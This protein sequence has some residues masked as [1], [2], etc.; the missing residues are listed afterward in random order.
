[1]KLFFLI[2]SLAGGG[3]EAV[4]LRLQGSI[5]PDKIILLENDAK[6]DVNKE[7]AVIL[8][9]H[10]NKTNP[11]YK[12]F[13]IPFYV[14]KILKKFKIGQDSV[15]ISFLERS[16][17]VN[18]ITKMIIKHKAIVT[19]H[20]DITNKK[21]F[22]KN[23][24]K[25]LMKLLYPK[26]DVIISVSN[27]VKEALKKMG[28]E[29]SKIKTIYNS[30]PIEEI[31]EKSKYPIEDI[32]N[33]FIITVGR[34]IEPKGQWYLLRIFKEVKKQFPDLKLVI[35]GEG[36]LKNYLVDL[37][38]RLGLKTFVWDKDNLNDMYDVYFLGFKKNPYKY[39][40]KAKF[41]VLTS[42]YEGFGNVLVE[43]MICNTCIISTDC[44]SG[45]REILAPETNF[46]LQ[47]KKP[48]ITP[49]GVLM[50]VFDGKFKKAGETLSKEEGIWAKTLIELLQNGEEC[51]KF[52]LS[53][54][55]RINDF[56]LEKIAAQWE[57]LL[58]KQA[59]D[60]K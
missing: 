48:E 35:L 15:V 37:S 11:I 3:A 51:D 32:F 14:K 1:M 47:T 7:Q 24:N 18:I 26:A 39:I 58:T 57:E 53:T 2:N 36:E 52:K 21:G 13:Y 17:Y 25:V 56:S 20:S 8:S 38:T 10:N 43:S 22:K 29:E 34:F 16:N 4:L 12:T 6:Y 46:K 33:D 30:F 45:P 42:L 28:I 23:I 55:S 49:Y 41:F 40:S 59:S 19:V 5:K 9:N 50:P 54:S 60:K 27:G 31:K 44:K